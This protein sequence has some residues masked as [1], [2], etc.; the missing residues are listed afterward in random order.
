MIEH[1]IHHNLTKY[2]DLL[3]HISCIDSCSQQK[4][5]IRG[6]GSLFVRNLI[7]KLEMLFQTNIYYDPKLGSGKR[8]KTEK[9][10]KAKEVKRKLKQ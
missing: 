1:L 3:L 2:S 5:K 7:V 10:R 9:K 6:P 8:L 4:L